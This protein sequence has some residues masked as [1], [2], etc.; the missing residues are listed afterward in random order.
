MVVLILDRQNGRMRKK[1]RRTNGQ[2]IMRNIA[3]RKPTFFDIAKA[4]DNVIAK[5]VPKTH[6][7]AMSPTNLLLQ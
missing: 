7:F 3:E 1:R 6:S 4:Y 2:K 5:V